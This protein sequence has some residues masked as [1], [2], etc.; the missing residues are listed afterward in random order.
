MK[1]VGIIVLVVIL[2]F[3]IVGCDK[4]NLFSLV[5]KWEM[6]NISYTTAGAKFDQTLS[7]NE[8]GYIIFEEDNTFYT[9]EFG[10]VSSIGNWTLIENGTLI[11]TTSNGNSL[12]L[13][14]TVENSNMIL[15]E[16][17]GEYQRWKK[18]K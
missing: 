10:T 17:S 8:K 2:C 4:D 6:S 15:M 14:I 11:C 13:D 5:G 9:M 12:I 7:N 1:R 18:V 3:S 16:N